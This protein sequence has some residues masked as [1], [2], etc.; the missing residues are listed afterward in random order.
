MSCRS[1]WTVLNNALPA[2]AFSLVGVA[3][4]VPTGRGFK[5]SVSVS[6]QLCDPTYAAA[7]QHVRR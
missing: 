4:V 7:N 5:L 6:D 2:I 3:D 1:C